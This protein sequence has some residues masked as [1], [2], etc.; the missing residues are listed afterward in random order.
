MRPPDPY[1]THLWPLAFWLDRVNPR[2]LE[3]GT[4]YYSTPLI[5]AQG[6]LSVEEDQNWLSH[7]RKFYPQIIS[8]M[9]RVLS[10]EK[11]GVVLIDSCIEGERVK[12]LE[13]LRPNGKVFILH[14][15]NPD[16]DSVYGYSKIRGTF[17]Y[18]RDYADFYPHTLV[19]S[20]V[21]DLHDPS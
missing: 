8:P 13:R 15:S 3:I 10:E 14:D 9:G 17:K 4:G 20:N 2:P 18:A 19:L 1:S 5:Q 6:G 11:F 12:W 7:M 16:W 21:V